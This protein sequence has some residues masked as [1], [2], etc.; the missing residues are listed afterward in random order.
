[1][2]GKIPVDDSEK[3]LEAKQ[4]EDH[5][6]DEEEEI[7][8]H[9][10]SSESDSSDEDEGIDESAVDLGKLP[11]VAKDDATVKSK[12]EKAKRIQVRINLSF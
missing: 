1:M 4:T 10:F 5:E 2:S 7:L 6:E 8:L 3:I 9:G 12:L 11:T